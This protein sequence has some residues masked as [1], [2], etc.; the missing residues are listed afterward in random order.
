MLMIGV[1][2]QTTRGRLA[3]GPAPSTRSANAWAA[4]ATTE[5]TPMNHRS[6]TVTGLYSYSCLPPLTAH[7][8]VS[9]DIKCVPLEME[10]ND[11][12]VNPPVPSSEQNGP[13]QVWSPIFTSPTTVE[14]S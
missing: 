3:R 9:C 6:P 4:S 2:P 8:T 7:F 1:G 13:I 11:P 12:I 10:Q 5:A 14:E